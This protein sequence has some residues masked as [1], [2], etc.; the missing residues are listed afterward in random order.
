MKIVFVSQP[1]ST[2]GAERVIA[3]LANKFY[4]MGNEVKIIVVDNGDNNVY[5]TNS[6]IEF[7]H[8]KKFS[9]PLKDLLYRAKVM[10]KYFRVYAPDII[11]PFTTQKNVSTLLATLFTRHKVIVSERNNPYKDPKSKLLRILRK[12]LYWTADGFVFQTQEAQAYFSNKIQKR[13]CIIENPL[14]ENLPLPWEGEREKNIVMV[15]RLDPQKNIKMAIDAF[16][17]VVRK[18]PEYCLE[19]FGKGPLEEEIRQYILTKGL[20]DKI[21]LRGFCKDVTEKIRNA[22]VYLLTSDFEGMS[23]SLMESLAMG[24][25]CISTDHPIGGARALIKDHENGILIPV[26]DLEKCVTA[27]EELID[28]KQ[29]REKL[30]ENAIKLRSDLSIDKVANRWMDYIKSLTVKNGVDYGRD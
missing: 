30:S 17:E 2:G 19:I 25:P 16:S 1:L 9:N 24:L 14:S 22:G 11:L 5:Y 27:L 4:E 18:H 8:I 3:A 6:E 13:S 15:N 12:M 21:F 26:S 29:L 28:D 23:N 7:V 20:S 10:R